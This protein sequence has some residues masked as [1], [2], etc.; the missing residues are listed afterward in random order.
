MITLTTTS[1]RLAAGLAATA[2]AA[3]MSTPVSLQAAAM[4]G[5]THH[6]MAAS[7]SGVYVCTKCKE[8]FSSTAAKKMGY[9]D[10]MGHKLT[11]VSKAPSG[12]A[13]GAKAGSM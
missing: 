1:R 5:K 6:T 11:K 9:K 2:L 7:K 3:L 10:G 12:Y 8:Y 4:K 13:D